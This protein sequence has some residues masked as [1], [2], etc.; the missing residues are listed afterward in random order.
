MPLKRVDATDGFGRDVHQ[1][2]R[3]KPISNNR[4]SK[5]LTRRR[6]VLTPMQGDNFPLK[7]KRRAGKIKE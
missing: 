7:G 2:G 5:S 6:E 1:G 3:T 4:E